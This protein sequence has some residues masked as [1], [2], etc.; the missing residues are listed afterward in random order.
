[1]SQ[2]NNIC[3]IP[4]LADASPYFMRLRTLGKRVWLDSGKPNSKYGRYDIISAIPDSILIG[5]NTADIIEITQN[6]NSQ[7]P[8]DVAD[9]DLPF[10]GGLLGYF[11]YEANHTEYK[12]N[13]YA[14]KLSVFGIYHWAL[15][16]DHAEKVS[17][18][19]F[20]RGFDKSKRNQ[21]LS[22]LTNDTE[23]QGT[24][25]VNGLSSNILRNQY[26]DAVQKIDHYIRSGDA[27]Q[28]NFS[29]RFSGTFKGDADIAYLALRQAL[30]SPF[31][32]YLELTDDVI[33]SLS[34]ERFIQITDGKA[35]T[36][37]IKG[38]ITRGKN[39]LQDE[40]FAASLLKSQKNRAE[41][42]MIVDLLR[43]D[44]SRGCL[45]HTV[46]TPAL[47]EL[48]SF[49]NVHHLV[50]NVTGVLRENIHPIEF[51]MQC[52]PGGSITGAPKKRAMEIINE[53]ES[54]PREIY[55]GSILYLSADGNLDSNIAIRTLMVRHNEIFCWGGG[56]IV[57]DSTPEDEYNE[58]FAKIQML[59]NTLEEFSQ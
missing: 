59:I 4:Y 10:K 27:Y 13:P 44:F 25:S 55:C 2:S 54:Q 8:K 48:Q 9:L 3:Q 52:F 16:V 28:I 14:S 36:H 20:L 29:Q 42:I 21:I 56:G 32:A 37:P 1:M 19:L 26:Y 22:T 47:C 50:S 11:N 53:L 18:C 38:T 57:A 51:F 39:K 35:T 49:A 31:S 41:N 15:V 17:Y 43:N 12:L 40:K 33:L 46:K 24:Y 7:I 34:P 6:L 5:K 45:P 23:Q 58:S 30:P